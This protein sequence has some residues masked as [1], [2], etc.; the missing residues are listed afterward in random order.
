M[1]LS[2]NAAPPRGIGLRLVP[3][4]VAPALAAN[5]VFALVALA[6]GEAL[7]RVSGAA[8]GAAPQPPSLQRFGTAL[9]AGFG[10]CA[11]AGIPLAACGYWYGKNLIRF[12]N[13]V[14]PFLFGHPGLTAGEYREAVDAVSLAASGPRN[15]P[16]FLAL[17]GRFATLPNA[18][19]AVSFVLAPLALGR[20][21][22]PDEPRRCSSSTWPPTRRTGSGWPRTRTGS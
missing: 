13:P 18:T 15:I 17:P 16:T 22:G 9:L 10:G 11:L 6:L 14:F 20:R 7:L 1:E 19:A 8:L 21:A 12:G 3:D 5:A 2:G 4:L